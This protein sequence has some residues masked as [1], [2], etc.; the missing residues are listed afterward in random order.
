MLLI[1]LSLAI[2]VYQIFISFSWDYSIMKLGGSVPIIF[3][4]G[5]GPSVAI[6]YIQIVY[7]YLSPNEDK[8]LLRQRRE[9]G[10]LVDRELG[11]VKRPAWWRLVRG[12]HLHSLRDKIHMNVSEVG[13]GRATGRRVEEAA[14]REAREEA[15]REARGDDDIE[16]SQMRRGTGTG[17]P[18]LDRAGAKTMS[19]SSPR[20]VT[21]GDDEFGEPS[22]P[23]PYS[24]EARRQRLAQRSNSD[25]SINSISSPPQQVRSMLDV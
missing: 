14:E 3:G 4:W 15:L 17:N 16:L 21:F 7:G 13:G 5:Y 23:P 20:A 12:D 6:L 25:S 8:A 2:V 24:D 18:R 9:R 10:D 19:V 11:L 1:P 22:P